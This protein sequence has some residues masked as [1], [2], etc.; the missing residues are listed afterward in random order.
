MGVLIMSK[1]FVVFLMI[2]FL[3][4]CGQRNELAPVVESRW[5]ENNH[6]S[7]HV[8]VRGE[9]LYAIAFR[10]DRDYRQLAEMNHLP[11]PY[12]LR[13]GQ[14]ISLSGSTR[15]R[16]P[17]NARPPTKFVPYTRRQQQ[18]IVPE[19]SRSGHWLWP[20]QGR[21]VASFAPAQGKKG[22]DIAGTKGSQIHAASSG[23][24][25]YAG[26]GLAGYGNLI[27]IRH[28][29]QFMTA[30]GNN[31]RNLVKEGQFVK[32]GQII[33]DMGIVD[34]RYWGVHFEIRYA[35]KPVNPRNYL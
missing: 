34:R 9:T 35:G 17:V 4:A 28:D 31:S 23:I 15:Y 12:T 13:V 10:Y 29:K 14:V 8:V 25:A 5:R 6:T 33:A 21:V 18:V 26:S 16:T 24:V 3:C 11:S 27:I 19:K 2:L 7:R 20:A 22:V 32:A 30:Y 1:K